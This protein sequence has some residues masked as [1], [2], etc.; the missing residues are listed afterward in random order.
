LLSIFVVDVG[1]L[2]IVKN[3]TRGDLPVGESPQ[4]LSNSAKEIIESLGVSVPA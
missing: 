2:T 4:N 1:D 3:P